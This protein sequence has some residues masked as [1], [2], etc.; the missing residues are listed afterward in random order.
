MGLLFKISRGPQYDLCLI[1]LTCDI[2]RFCNRNSQCC[3]ADR[4]VV[5]AEEDSKLQLSFIEPATNVQYE[6]IEWYKGLKQP[7]GRI[8]MV[9]HS[10][11]DQAQYFNQYCSA[12]SP[13]QSSD[14]GV[15]DSKTGTMTIHSVNIIDEDFYYYYFSTYGRVTQ[16][17]GEKYEIKV[18]IFGKL[19]CHKFFKKIIK[20]AKP[21]LNNVEYALKC[22][23]NCNGF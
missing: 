3:F 13:C 20:L 7:E 6:K 23:I 22:M 8:A 11:S 15:L 16:D 14:K 21:L 5:T 17:T 10:L 9:L 18:E 1:F 12:N 2:R 4:Q 19:Y